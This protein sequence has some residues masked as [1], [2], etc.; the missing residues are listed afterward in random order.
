[1]KK[2]ALIGANGQLGTDIHKVF[3]L[4][5]HYKVFPLTTREIDVTS[6]KLTKK[7]LEE[8]KP[9]IV[10]NTAAYHRVDEVEDNPEKAFVVNSVAEKNLAELC[11]FHH[12]VLV[13]ISTDYVFGLDPKRTKPYIEIDTP[14]PINV[15][16]V[17]KL[18]GEY[19]TRFIC[20]KHF[21]IRLCGLFGVVG[22]LGKGGNFVETMIKLGKEKG[23]AKV[24]NDQILTPTYTKNI[25]ENIGE[26]LKTDYYGLYHMTSE[27]RCSWWEF[28]SEIFR[29][30]KMKVKCHPVTSDVFKTRAKRP[31]FSVLENYNLKKLGLNKMREWKEN[32][33]LYLKEKGHL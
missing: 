27:G 20:Q 19:L 8:I 4:D 30:L 9:Q 28:T 11:E 16:G 7:V 32:L 15:Y 1:M 23:K 14:G 10:I 18:A 5:N 12:W 6:L 22:A 13:F 17:S 21:V 26:L 31:L 25:A 29:L 33:K 2:V 3:S 24:V